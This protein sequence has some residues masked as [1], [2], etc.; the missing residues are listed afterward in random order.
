MSYR[1][2]N[3]PEEIQAAVGYAVSLLLEAGKP[4]HM[5]EITALLQQHAEQASDESLKNHLLHAIR[6]IA[7][8]MN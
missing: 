5:Y 2:T 8:K 4:I 7:D 6:L 3:I 1:K